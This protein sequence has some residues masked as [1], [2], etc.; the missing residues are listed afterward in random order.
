M[1]ENTEKANTESVKVIF[2]CTGNTCRSCMAEGLLK[3]ALKN[4]SGAEKIS[5]VS[6]GIYALDGDPASDHSIKALKDLWGIDISTHRAK[7]LSETEISEADLILA[8]TRQHRDTLKQ[9]YPRKKTAIFTLK[10]YVYPDITSDSSSADISDPYGMPYNV[11]ESCARELQ[12]C[13]NILVN[14]LSFF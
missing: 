9:K 10:E 1:K 8:M 13:I 12:K 14:K 11:Y 3:E 6:R 5:A 7:I 2:I 4:V